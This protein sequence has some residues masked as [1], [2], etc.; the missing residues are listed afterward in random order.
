MGLIGRVAWRNDADGAHHAAIFVFEQV[1]VVDE[2]AE[3]VG[4]AKIHAQ[5]DAGILQGAAV[6]VGDVDG[7][8]EERLV[9]GNAVPVEQFEMNLMN[10]EGVEFGAAILDDPVFDVALLHDDIGNGG[11]RVERCGSLAVDGDEESG[12][13]VG[14]VGVFELLG[15]IKFADT[16]GRDTA[17]PWQGG[18]RKGRGI[19]SQGGTGFKGIGGGEDGGE[20]T[21]GVVLAALAGVNGASNE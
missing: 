21:V 6:V 10:V 16:N 9:D 8:A 7:V 20:R 13:A 19:G 5:A 15:K 12:G 14:I 17:E 11:G 2:G 1:T 4:I 3:G 18:G